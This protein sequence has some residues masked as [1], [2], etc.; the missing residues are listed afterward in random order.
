VRSVRF[1]PFEVDFD[2][3]ELRKSGLKLRLTGQPI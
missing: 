1:G 2:S 3:G